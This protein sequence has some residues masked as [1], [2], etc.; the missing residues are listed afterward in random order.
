MS[1]KVK[2]LSVDQF[3]INEVKGKRLEDFDFSS[4]PDSPK[5]RSNQYKFRIIEVE[6]DQS[7]ARIGIV[8]FREDKEGALYLWKY[9]FDSSD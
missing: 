3:K 5:K 4:M 8:W 7:P 6:E 9:R 2:V 1:K